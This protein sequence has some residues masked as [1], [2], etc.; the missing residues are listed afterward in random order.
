MHEVF[1]S[2]LNSQTIQFTSHDEIKKLRENEKP[3]SSYHE[4][5]IKQSS[6]H[7]AVVVGPKSH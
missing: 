7:M 2:A 3:S 5:G 1:K 6:L 4:K